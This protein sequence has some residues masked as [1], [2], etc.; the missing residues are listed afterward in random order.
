MIRRAGRVIALKIENSETLF[1][2]HAEKIDLRQNMH[3]H[4]A[5]TSFHGG[6]VIDDRKAIARIGNRHLEI[7]VAADSRLAQYQLANDR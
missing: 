3:L 2:E 7:D 4:R 5:F 1:V 6:E